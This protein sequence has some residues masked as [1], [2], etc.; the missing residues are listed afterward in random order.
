MHHSKEKLE[1]NALK[2]IDRLYGSL[3]HTNRALE[4]KGLVRFKEIVEG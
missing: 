3:K 1:K 4:K 2:D